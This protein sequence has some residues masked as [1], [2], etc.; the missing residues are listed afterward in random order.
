[1]SRH[2]S[3]ERKLEVIRLY[4]EGTSGYALSKQFKYPH[5]CV[6][7]WLTEACVIEKSRTQETAKAIPLVQQAM[8]N[9]PVSVFHLRSRA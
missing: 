6:Y 2:I 8:R 7:R 5:S 4:R 1:M 3:R 9:S